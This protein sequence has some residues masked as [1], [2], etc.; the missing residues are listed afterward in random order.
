MGN[1]VSLNKVDPSSARLPFGMHTQKCRVGGKVTDFFPETHC[2][3][4]DCPMNER[5]CRL[6][7]IENRFPVI[8]LFRNQNFPTYVI[9]AGDNFLSTPLLPAYQMS[10]AR[11]PAINALSRNAQRPPEGGLC[12]V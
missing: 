4:A 10:A 11:A 8:F 7:D 12:L 9:A 3:R 1:A 2:Y 6:S 5:S